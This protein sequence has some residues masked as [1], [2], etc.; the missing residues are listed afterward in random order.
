M[1]TQFLDNR[2]VNYSQVGQKLR[3]KSWRK[4]SGEARG[5]S[6]V[7]F[8]SNGLSSFW[9]RLT[10]ETYEKFHDRYLE[11]IYLEEEIY[12]VSNRNSISLP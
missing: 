2:V 8:Y 10:A 9:L 12:A 5:R 6:L 4:I 7:G 1:N 3:G 11:G